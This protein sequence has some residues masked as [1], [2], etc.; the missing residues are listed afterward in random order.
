MKEFKGTKGT[1][2]VETAFE[3]ENDSIKIKRND[4]VNAVKDSIGRAI[5]FVGVKSKEEANY[6]ALLI[7]KSPLLLEMLNRLIEQI[8]NEHVSDI[9]DELTLEATNLIKQSTE[10]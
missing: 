5:C 2:S 8:S 9:M 3:D 4:D 6:N 7:S 10:L 1:W